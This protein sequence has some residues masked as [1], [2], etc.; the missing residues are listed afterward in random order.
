MND[1]PNRPAGG[2]SRRRLLRHAAAGSLL[3]PMPF[4]ARGALAEETFRVGWIRPTTG[5]LASSF[6]PLYAGGLI[7]IDE[8][9]AAGGI[10]GRKV[11]TV[12][13]DDEASP[14]KQPAV[15]K[16][17]K[18][19][20]VSYVV[21]PTGS[22]QVLSSLAFTTPAQM[23]QCG[24]A[25]AADQGDAAKYPY[26]YMCVWST[27]QEGEA[28]AAYMANQ[29]KIRKIGLLQE[30]TPF[31]EQAGNATK[32]KFKELTGQ[33]PASVQV[34]PATATD[35]A[36][37]VKNLQ[38]AGCEGVIVWM[39][40]TVH[41]GM[42]FNAMAQQ[43]WLPPVI[44]HVNLFN[45]SLFD[46]VPL[47]ALKNVY[48]IY[49][50]N[51]TYTGSE[52]VPPRNM[53]LARKLATVESAKGIQAFVAGCPHYDF[54]YLLKTA[55]EQAK[56][57]EVAAVKKA[58]DGI[59]GYKAV[60][61]TINFSETSHAGIGMEDVTLASVASAKDPRSFGAIRERAPGA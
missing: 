58:L 44:G 28:A 14:A 41:I 21:G 36:P 39:A 60:L 23:I 48:G 54:L 19:A 55:V 29:L 53:E 27:E 47:E 8:I 40:N 17:L 26:N 22:P 42:A 4:I 11:V 57:T 43:K 5:R 10:L 3:L 32:R 56:S 18:D 51:W 34:Y 9:N 13:E 35:L 52:Q 20:G 49:Y 1:N 33:D 15:I 30:S 16:R 12:E 61:G 25:N 31:G 46:L 7:A 6:A 2:L 38:A 37:Y 59:R 24:I 45:D 50:K